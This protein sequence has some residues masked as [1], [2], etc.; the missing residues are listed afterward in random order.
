MI[1]NLKKE[2]EDIQRKWDN[3]G[4]KEKERQRIRKRTIEK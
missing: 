1:K 2:I 3:E 4:E